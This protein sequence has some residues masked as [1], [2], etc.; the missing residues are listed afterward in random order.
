MSA[1][2]AGTDES[3]TILDAWRE[4]ER[5]CVPNDFGVEQR[6]KTKYAFYCAASTVVDRFLGSQADNDEGIVEFIHQLKVECQELANSIA[7]DVHA[8]RPR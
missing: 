4:F 5:H 2:D 6:R 8:P 7:E 1:R 3:G